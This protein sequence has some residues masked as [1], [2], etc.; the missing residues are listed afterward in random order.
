MNEQVK[1]IIIIIVI[2]TIIFQVYNMTYKARYG[3][4]LHQLKITTVHD[5]VKCFFGEDGCEE[6]DI[7]G[8]TLIHGLMYGLI[9]YYIPNHYLAIIII[10]IV[11][12]LVQPYLGNRARYIVNPLVNLTGY[13][14]GSV[15]SK[16]KSFKEKYQVIEK[17]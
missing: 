15:L 1:K 4:F 8:W 14:I 13:G 3:D 12:E 5:S 17:S 6:G 7:D 9:G 11:F 10:S 2:L 16:K